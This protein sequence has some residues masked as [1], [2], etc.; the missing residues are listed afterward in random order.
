MRRSRIM[1]VILGFALWWSTVDKG[2]GKLCLGHFGKA[3]TT[4]DAC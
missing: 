1:G 4:D 2:R 3:D